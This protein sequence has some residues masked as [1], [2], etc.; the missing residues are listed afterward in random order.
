MYLELTDPKVWGTFFAAFV[1]CVVV[2]LRLHSRQKRWRIPV[3]SVGPNFDYTKE[4]PLR[5]YPFTGKPYNLTMGIKRLDPQDWLLVEDTYKEILAER[6]RI[7]TNSHPAYPKDKDLRNCTL[8]ELPDADFAI[9]EL[10]DVMVQYMCDKYP[11]IFVAK[12]NK[13]TNTVSTQTFPQKALPSQSREELLDILGQNI[14]EDFLLLLKDPSVP[15]NNGEYVLKAGIFA[16]AAGFN[17]RTK[18]NKPLTA[19]HG[20]VPGYESKLKKSMN[21]YFDRVNATE[22]VTRSN[23]SVQTH[24]KFYVDDSNK[25]YHGSGKPPVDY[26]LLDFSRQVNYRS[27]RQ[28]LTKLPESGAIVFTTRTYLHPF[29]RFKHDFPEDGKRLLASLKNF[30]TDMAFYKNAIEW[31]PAATRYLDEIAV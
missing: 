17:P 8:L 1:S 14:E 29:S 13:V 27:E 31:G 10:Y 28:T 18:L 22:F 11:M 12:D 16:F 7:L 4:Q 6:K 24:T 5:S 19:I 2:F 20:P 25:G 26:D 30:S 21:R 3:R 9:R 23:F 15:D